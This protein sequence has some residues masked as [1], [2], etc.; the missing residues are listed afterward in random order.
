MTSTTPGDFPAGT[1]VHAK[2]H[3]RFPRIPTGRA[4]ALGPFGDNM[5]LVW[6]WP[7]GIVTPGVT[8][9]AMFPSELTPLADTLADLHLTVLLTMRDNV[10]AITS[11]GRLFDDLT[12]LRTLLVTLTNGRD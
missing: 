7:L 6:H 12:P 8:A 10:E 4:V 3:P 11:R 2:P 1:L 5:V 9:H